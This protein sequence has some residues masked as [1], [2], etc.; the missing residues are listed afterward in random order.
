MFAHIEFDTRYQNYTFYVIFF[1][2]Y[3]LERRLS[4]LNLI[5]YKNSNWLLEKVIR[6]KTNRMTIVYFSRSAEIAQVRHVNT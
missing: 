5:D 3:V 1:L 2:K 4:T 6:D